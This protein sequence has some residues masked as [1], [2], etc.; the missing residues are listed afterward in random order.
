M[1]G[2]DCSTAS[3]QRVQSCGVHCQQA[4]HY[5]H[6][7]RE[8][9]WTQATKV[10]NILGKVCAQNLICLLKSTGWML[11]GSSTDRMVTWCM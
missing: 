10:F 4:Q 5:K 8:A 7:H 6:T 2:Q 3:V 1:S 9:L 11:A